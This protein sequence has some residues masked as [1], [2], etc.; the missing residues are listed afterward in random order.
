MINF[1]VFVFI[2]V[3]EV[4]KNGLFGFLPKYYRSQVENTLFDST[5]IEDILVTPARM[6][7]QSV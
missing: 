1:L 5:E 4:N 2:F 3:H 7:K 6:S